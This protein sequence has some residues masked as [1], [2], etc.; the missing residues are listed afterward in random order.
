MVEH[1]K[2]EILM[3]R[4]HLLKSTIRTICIYCLPDKDIKDDEFTLTVTWSIE[5]NNFSL[6]FRVEE[7]ICMDE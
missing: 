6:K 1:K 3:L 2:R 4:F 5:K 7:Y